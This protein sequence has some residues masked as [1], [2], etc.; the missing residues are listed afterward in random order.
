MSHTWQ[1]RRI[2]F[3]S[4]GFIVTGLF[5]GNTL[6][7]YLGVIPL[8]Y[9][10]L[11]LADSMPKGV[12]LQPVETSLSA[13][14]DGELPLTRII[15]LK[16]GTGVVSLGEELPSF[17]K[18]VEGNNIRLLWKNPGE[19]EVI[20]NYRVV[21]SKRGL[22]RLDSLHAESRHP[23]LLRPSMITSLK[24]GQDLIVT[25]R[26]QSLRRIRQKKAFTRIPMPAD[27]SARIGSIT[28]D[29][30]ELRE[31]R[32]GD[33]YKSINWKAT[34]RKGSF[35]TGV[36]PTVN[37]YERE[38]RKLVYLFLDSSRSLE[39]GTT[40]HNSFEYA[41]EAILGISEYYLSRNCMVGLALFN[42]TPEARDDSW[43]NLFPDSGKKQVQRIHR[44]LLDLEAGRTG[45][46]L[47]ESARKTR[48]HILG[49]RPLYIIV[50]RLHEGNFDSLT[51]GIGRLSVSAERT[52]PR[53][54]L[55]NVSGYRLGEHGQVSQLASKV[56]E[57][58]EGGLVRRLRASGIQAVN[59]YPEDHGIAHTLLTQGV[60]R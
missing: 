13:K 52:S 15:R 51:E 40:V 22:Y 3:T 42:S 28:T 7:I 48:R 20:L 12:E 57:Y 30:K 45:L 5:L 38:G 14:T 27:A 60:K 17:F 59:W 34:A 56:M 23:S 19:K 43:V 50:T 1:F 8:A 49:S 16:T 44:L 18:L 21:C 2:V 9:S 29:F 36:I 33:S 25:P 31:Y 55:V 46:S 58:H 47:R 4:I 6:M 24:L 41:L 53:V 39:V 35:S 11:T 10:L 54:L 32:Y 37:E 26:T